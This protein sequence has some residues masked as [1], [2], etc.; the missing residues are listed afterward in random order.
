ML[1]EPCTNKLLLK[2]DKMENDLLLSDVTFGNRLFLWRMIPHH[3]TLWGTFKFWSFSVQSLRELLALFLYSSNVWDQF[4]CHCWSTVLIRIML[5][6]NL[7][8]MA[9]CTQSD[10]TSTL[11]VWFLWQLGKV[12]P[13]CVILGY[14]SKIRWVEFISLSCFNS[15]LIY[16]F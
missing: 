2:I 8:F 14:M 1:I 10:L 4:Y 11:L 5:I 6:C 16:A 7:L 9:N 12:A 3:N 13:H 15:C